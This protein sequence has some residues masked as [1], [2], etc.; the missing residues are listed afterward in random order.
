M[1][2]S[3]EALVSES[4]LIIREKQNT[5]STLLQYCNRVCFFTD[6]ND[7]CFDKQKAEVERIWNLIPNEKFSEYR[8]IL[9]L[10][11]QPLRDNLSSYTYETFEMDK[12][13]YNMYTE[14]LTAALIDLN[15][16]SHFENENNKIDGKLPLQILLL[17]AG[18]GPLIDCILQSAS[19]TNRAVYIT[20]IDKNPCSIM[21][22]QSRKLHE[23]WENVEVQCTDIRQ[24]KPKVEFEIILSELLGSFSDNELCPECLQPSE[25]ML[26]SSGIFIPNKYS[27][28]CQPICCG[29]LWGQ[30]KKVALPC[31]YESP[32]VVN[33]HS[34]TEIAEYKEI[35][36]FEHKHNKAQSNIP[37]MECVL[38]I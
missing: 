20:A 37:E 13:K 31:P 33:L 27:S 36:T 25:C 30:I 3:M 4:T 8:D 17:G 38:L 5:I 32:Y 19:K 26:S 22:L 18:R 15:S 21:C 1:L 23:K 11:L 16:H 14:A 9:Q 29:K 7:E 24:M 2:T 34:Y 10:A 35:F 6:D 28:F 12:T